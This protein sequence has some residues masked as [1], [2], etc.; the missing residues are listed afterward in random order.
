MFSGVEEFR[1]LEG[2]L[3]LVLARELE[4]GLSGLVRLCRGRRNGRVRAVVEQMRPKLAI[5]R[6]APFETML[7]PEVTSGLRRFFERE[8]RASTRELGAVRVAIEKVTVVLR[9]L[10]LRVSAIRGNLRPEGVTEYRRQL[11]EDLWTEPSEAAPAAG[12]ETDWRALPPELHRAWLDRLRTEWSRLNWYYLGEALRPPA[13]ELID[14]RTE[15]GRWNAEHRTIGL[16]GR[17][18]VERAWN[19][20]I[21]ALKHE[22]AH[23]VVSELWLQPGA[24]H[25]S[26][27]FR[28]ACERLRCDARA[29]AD[30]GKMVR[31]EDSE[32]PRDRVVAKIFKLLRLGASS[33]EHEAALAMERASALL[34]RYNLDVSSL[35]T[36]KTYFRRLIGPI[37][38]R[39]EEHH[40][41][42]G[43]ILGEHFFVHVIW[44]ISYL[45]LTAQGGTQLAI[46]G[47]RENLD[48]ADYVHDFLTRTLEHL[49]QEHRSSPR[50]RGGRK[51][52]YLAGVARGFLDKLHE[53]RQRLVTERALVFKSDGRLE[54]HIKHLYPR[55][56]SSGSSGVAR[57]DEYHAGVAKGREITLRMGVT[58]RSGTHGGLLPG[59]PSGDGE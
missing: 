9:I 7:D 39:R 4:A 21:E 33:N 55:L 22:M 35:G 8:V 3:F 56:S 42:L 49:W 13:F 52:Q 18:I 37:L 26:A 34:A 1:R 41:V 50:F 44:E 11:A 32:D 31:L 46:V 54:A 53:Q 29:T 20:V 30:P 51:A 14:S 12:R 10:D 16:S 23:Q 36:E 43:R 59:R 24:S 47:T 15:L 40:Q 6:A 5:L 17:L 28:S 58:E 27:A 57:G 45:P 48:V 38:L 25:D 19:E 2:Q